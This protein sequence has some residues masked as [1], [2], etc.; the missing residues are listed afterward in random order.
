MHYVDMK[1]AL[2]LLYG[3]PEMAKA[4]AYLGG[5]LVPNEEWI[6]DIDQ[7]EAWTEKVNAGEH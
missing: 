1:K 5:R 6:S 7:G 4:M 3:I 2:R